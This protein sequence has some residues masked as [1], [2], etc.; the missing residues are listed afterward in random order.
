LW[1]AGY[2]AGEAMTEPCREFGI[3]RKNLMSGINHIESKS[4]VRGLQ[5]TRRLLGKLSAWSNFTTAVRSPRK[6]SGILSM[7]VEVGPA[8]AL[9]ARI[10][11]PPLKAGVHATLDNLSNSTFENPSTEFSREGKVVEFSFSGDPAYRG[12]IADEGNTIDGTLYMSDGST[13]ISKWTRSKALVSTGTSVA[14]NLPITGDWSGLL[15]LN[16]KRSNFVLHIQE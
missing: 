11:Q 10:S 8:A 1:V 9:P 6:P 4:S 15:D 7:K 3:S 5:P 16:G 12:T 14:Q 2:L 13:A